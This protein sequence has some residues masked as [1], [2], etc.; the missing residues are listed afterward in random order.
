[1]AIRE[2]LGVVRDL[3]GHGVGHEV[4]EPP[5]I[6]NYEKGAS[7]MVFEEGMVIAL[8]PMFTLGGWR[9]RVLDDGWTFVT[10]DNSLSAHFEDTVALID[11]G[12]EILTR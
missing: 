3:V 12:S 4:H 11:G 2:D 5:Q 1:V 8:E 9:V 10:A 7:D 6:A